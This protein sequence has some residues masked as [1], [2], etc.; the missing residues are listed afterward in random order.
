M[1]HTSQPRIGITTSTVTQGPAGPIRPA[2]TIPLRYARCIYQAGGV[3]VLVPTLPE[4]A[5]ALLAQL[6][7]LLLSGGG[8][9]DP[10]HWDEPP[11]PALGVVDAERDAL[12]MALLL[13]A[14]RRDLPVLGICRGAQ[15][16]AV[17]TGG[18][19]W[20][21]IPAQCPHCLAHRQTAEFT[22]PTHAARILRD[23]PLARI[24]GLSDVTNPDDPRVMVNS[25]HHQ[26]V[27]KC[28]RVF[29]PVAWSPD[30]IIEGL[31]GASATFALGVQWH[32]EELTETDPRQHRLFTAFVQAAAGS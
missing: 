12:E 5:D 23:S 29:S 24:L 1:R 27:R 20:Q 32:A 28:G 21:D 9:I 4:A 15:V 30:G 11:H 26:A 22:Q 18:D 25:F 10:A 6:D 3:P 8:D 7:G 19:L 14:L 2:A 31:Y 16:M 17:T 13:A